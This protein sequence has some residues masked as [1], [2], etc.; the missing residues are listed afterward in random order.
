MPPPPPRPPLSRIAAVFRKGGLKATQN[1]FFSP[2]SRGTRVLVG[3][4]RPS[5]AC[6]LHKAHCTVC[7]HKKGAWGSQK[8]RE[9]GGE[10]GGFALIHCEINLLHIKRGDTRRNGT[11]LKAKT[12]FLLCCS[13]FQLIPVSPMSSCRFPMPLFPNSASLSCRFRL[14][15][16]SPVNSVSRKRL[17][18]FSTFSEEN[19]YFFT[20]LTWRRTAG[21]WRCLIS[22]PTAASAS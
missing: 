18:L 3:W 5:T 15:P 14:T 4:S 6:I 13:L 8:E 11:L 1:G 20:L 12:V 19:D 7:A 16:S 21:P 17:R 2:S 10:K 9:G 22:L